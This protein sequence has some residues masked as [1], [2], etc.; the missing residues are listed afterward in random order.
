MVKILNLEQELEICRLYTKDK[1]S[2]NE[3][4][5]LFNISVG[6]VIKTLERYNIKRVKNSPKNIK[7]SSY[8]KYNLNEDYFTMIDS[9]DKAYFLGLIIA[10]GT[11]SYGRTSILSIGLQEEDS[12]ILE[13][14]KKNLDFEGSIRLIKKS[15]SCRKDLKS[16]SICSKKLVE[17]LIKHGIIPNKTHF[18]YFPDI[19]E[20]FYSH[21]IR[22]VFDGDGSIV[23]DP[24]GRQNLTF[25]IAGTEVLIS[26]IQEILIE[27][28]DLNKTKLATSKQT[29]DTFRV[30]NYSGNFICKR[31][32]EYLYKNAESFLTR[33]KEK[34]ESRLN[35]L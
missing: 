17:S 32:Y 30:M 31:I 19:P 16:I 35:K 15:K 5:K 9:N 12:Y 26:K 6:T 20:E 23:L 10:D 29:K 34:F 11:I 25:S 1:L 22:G 14:L 27:N 13:K 24:R 3:I 28:C 7:K 2:S 8:R 33:K 21:F 4:R 18:T